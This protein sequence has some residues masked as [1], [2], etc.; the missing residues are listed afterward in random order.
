MLK[1]GPIHDMGFHN[2]LPAPFSTLSLTVLLLHVHTHRH[3]HTR[4]CMQKLPKEFQIPL[5]LLCTEIQ[6]SPTL[7]S[8]FKF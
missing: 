5:T 3:R 2:G 7:M 1:N 8:K 6:Y 4:A